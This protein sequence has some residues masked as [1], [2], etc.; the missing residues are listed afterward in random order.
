MTRFE[1]ELL[2]TVARVLRCHL[3]ETSSLP[4]EISEDIVD[5]DL[6]LKPFDPVDSPSVNEEQEQGK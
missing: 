5:L 3:N 1:R 6:A 2:L 4:R